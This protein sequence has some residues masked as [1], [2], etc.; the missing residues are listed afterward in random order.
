MGVHKEWDK[1]SVRAAVVSALAD[2]GATEFTHANF[3]AV[4]RI[5]EQVSDIPLSRRWRI[6]TRRAFE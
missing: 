5:M 4:Y 3:I 2:E 6:S 1:E